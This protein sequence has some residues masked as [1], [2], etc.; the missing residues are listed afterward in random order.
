MGSQLRRRWRPEPSR[1]SPT[2]QSCH[3][4]RREVVRELPRRPVERGPHELTARLRI[5]GSARWR[6][7]TPAWRRRRPVRRWAEAGGRRR[8]A[9]ARGRRR[10]PKAG[11]RIARR[12]VSRLRVRLRTC[13]PGF[14]APSAGR[15]PFI[16]TPESVADP[17]TG[18]DE[19]GSERPTAMPKPP[20]SPRQR[21]RT[22]TRSRMSP[23]ATHTR[24]SAV[25]ALLRTSVLTSGREC[26]R[27]TAT[28][29]ATTKP[30]A[31][32]NRSAERVGRRRPPLTVDEVD[33]RPGQAA[34]WTR[35]PGHQPERADDRAVLDRRRGR[36]SRPRPRLRP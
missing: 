33:P 5:A 15:S 21:V 14:A 12:R 22:S 1:S 23:N 27:T 6:R 36:R 30:T 24:P 18:R 7:W 11:W 25:A 3:E 9:E 8:R 10:R 20:D 17:S 2:A 29:V 4:Q 34:A 35:Q 19:Y 28:A 16:E 13:N 31:S 32:A 26:R